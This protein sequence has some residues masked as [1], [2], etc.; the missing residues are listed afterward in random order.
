[1]K[2]E[3][4]AEIRGEFK[5]VP[6]NVPGISVCE[7]LPRLSRWMHKAAI[8]RS[9]RHRGGDHNPLPSYTG[10]ERPVD[11]TFT[12]DTYPPSMGSVCEYLKKGPRQLPAYVYLPNY[13]GWGQ[14]IRRPGPYAGF[15]GKRYDALYTEVMPHRN[16]N[17]PTPAP[18][19]PVP[20]LGERRLPEHTLTQR[21]R[22]DRLR[23]RRS[24][25]HWSPD[26]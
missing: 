5:P 22:A 19:R 12:L 7:L 17:G 8:V 21:V 20:V 23:P 9:V 11:S 25:H 6:S 4:P 14:A 1:L 18:G 2:P 3:A 10:D 15:L 16:P 24:L 13:L 26:T